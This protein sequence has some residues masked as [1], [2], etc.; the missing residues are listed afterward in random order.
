A[1]VPILPYIFDAGELTF[2][3]SAVLSALALIVVGGALAG[4]TSRSVLWGSLRMLMAG[5]AA[6]AVTFG[7][8]HLI[9]VRIIG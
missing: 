5:G 9:G 4:L 8:G 2:S 7:I 6:A 1:I 3:L